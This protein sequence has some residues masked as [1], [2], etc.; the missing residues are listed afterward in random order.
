MTVA[1]IKRMI[2]EEKNRK[3]FFSE[4]HFNIREEQI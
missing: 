2:A 4:Y 1:K 3:A